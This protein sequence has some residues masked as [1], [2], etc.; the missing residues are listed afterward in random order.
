MSDSKNNRRQ[1]LKNASLATLALGLSPLTS[2]A[3][4]TST[5]Q[6]EECEKTTADY[7]GEGP[8][9]TANPP[10][11]TDG[12]LSSDTETGTKIRITGRVQNLIV[13]NLF[14]TQ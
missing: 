7:Y 8:F 1:F 14:P 5:S 2:K 6:K 9:Y 13:Q 4:S 11:L 12:K 10:E 3:S